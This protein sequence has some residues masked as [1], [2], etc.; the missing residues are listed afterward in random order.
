MSVHLPT[1]LKI[2]HV[3]DSLEFGGLERF[4]LDLAT[5]QLT[6]GYEVTIFSILRTGGYVTDVVNA[7]IQVIQAGK[8]RSFDVSVLRQ[9]RAASVGA[10]VDVVHAHN[11]TPNYYAAT[12]ILGS[13][14]RRPTLVGTCHD[15]GARLSNRHLRRMYRWAL[16]RTTRVSMVSQGVCDQYMTTGLVDPR[17]ATTI[18]NGVPVERF[19]N[20]PARRAAG[21]AALGLSGDGL[22][23]GTVGR[24]VKLKNHQMLIGVVPELVRSFP[25]LQV[26]IVGY[27]ELEDALRQQIS[28]LGMQG[29]ITLTGKRSDVADILPAFD[30]YC[31]PSLTEGLPIALLEA[32]ASSLAIVATAVGG[33]AEVISNGETG[34]LTRPG[35][36]A[37]FRDA[38]H[39]L[40]A[41][42]TLRENVA[43]AARVWVR[44]H[45]SMEILFA[46]Y[47]SFYRRAMSES[48]K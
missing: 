18:P 39:R 40:L 22:V 2:L 17:R 28:D 30:V 7:G 1:A 35:D 13:G 32:C 43:N 4:V 6:S 16:R 37:G 21:R 23:I 24:Y 26:V 48:G 5:K 46:A 31:T 34:L 38:L 11:F 42:A 36:P 25:D 3:V 15:M 14:S 33:N 8:S 20:S 41:D 12:A 9:L 44:D 29:H 27:G 45:A 19:A 10:R 47:D